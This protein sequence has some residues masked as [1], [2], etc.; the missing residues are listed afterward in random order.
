MVEIYGNAFTASY[1]DTPGEIWMAAIADLSEAELGRGFTTLSKQEREFPPN[2]TQFVAACRPPISSPRFLGTPTTPD[3]IR[4]L[5][6]PK[7][8][9]API[10]DV[11]DWLASMR[12][13]VAKAEIKT[14][15]AYPKGQ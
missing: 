11:E 10:S 9:M 2:L 3:E 14:S 5:E 1:G 7:S 4:K 15:P 12:E 6:P 8:C 13:N